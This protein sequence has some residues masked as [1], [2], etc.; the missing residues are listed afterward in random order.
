MSANS[1]PSAASGKELPWEITVHA[2]QDLLT[3]QADFLLLDCR[4]TSEYEK[5]CIVPAQLIP[6]GQI[7]S[8]VAELSAHPERHIVVHCHHGGRSLRVA[9]FLRAQG[10]PNVQS[11]QGGIDQWSQA[12]DPSIPRY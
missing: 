9:Q 1:S 4:E 7:P 6:M 10:L 8:R 12:I 2:V 11:M 5:A 3:Q